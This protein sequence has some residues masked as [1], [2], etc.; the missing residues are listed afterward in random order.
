MNQVI[1]YINQFKGKEFTGTPSPF[2]KWLN[3][4]VKHVEEGQAQLEFRVR[5]EMTNPAGLL[6][7]GVIASIIDEVIGIATYSL[8]D[9]KT[10]LSIN[11][12]ID[13]LAPAKEDD[14]VIATASINKKG[15]QIINATCDL[16]NQQGKLLARGYSNLL[17]S[18]VPKNKEQ[19]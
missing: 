13:Y 15:R 6:H 7:G 2:G 8:D 9:N 12:N 4:I 14:V 19:G 11:L 10:K 5:K 18:E 3:G 17:N 16:H 1:A